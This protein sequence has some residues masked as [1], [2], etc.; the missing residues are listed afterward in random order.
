VVSGREF[1]ADDGATAPAV[2]VINRSAARQYFGSTNPVGQMIDW[3]FRPGQPRQLTVV[4]VVN[5]VRQTSPTDDVFPEVFLDYRQFLALLDGWQE[6]AARQ[7]ELAIGFLSF[8]VRIDGDPSAAIPVIRQAVTGV[9]PSIGVDGIVP[10]E[11][12]VASTLTRQRFYAVTMGV[13]AGI[14]A[15]LAVIGVYAVFTYAVGRRTQEIGI[16]MALGARGS[17]VMGLVLR[18]SLVLTAVGVA[19]GMIGA[20]T[21]ARYLESLL[22][23]VTRFDTATFA[24][25]SIVFATVAML[26]SYIPAQRAARVDLLIA[27]RY[28]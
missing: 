3:H 11:R 9:D 26:A 20:A 7:N 2:V 28:E 23:G 25:V 24:A 18:Q 6:A 21:L 10:L 17:R 19:T 27:L 15:I 14:A 22:F 5:D 1:T 12:L 4:G 8:A 16:R 13:F